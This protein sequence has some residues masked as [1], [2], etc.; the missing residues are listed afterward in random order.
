MIF[1]SFFFF[2]KDDFSHI[3][4][5]NKI[6]FST[7]VFS[8]ACLVIEEGL[9]LKKGN[10]PFP[11]YAIISLFQKRYFSS[12]HHPLLKFTSY[13]HLKKLRRNGYIN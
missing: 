2:G 4:K 7:D 3:I 8:V 13:F 5:A 11:P 6:F 12:L 10:V 9:D 1:F